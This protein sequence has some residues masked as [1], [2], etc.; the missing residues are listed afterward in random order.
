M[1]AFPH[2]LIH[3]VIYLLYMNIHDI[4]WILLVSLVNKPHSYGI[5]GIQS[6]TMSPWSILVA[7]GWSPRGCSV[8][9]VPM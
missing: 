5:H 6:L 2:V 4:Y 9:S 7:L 3:H 1:N 8:W